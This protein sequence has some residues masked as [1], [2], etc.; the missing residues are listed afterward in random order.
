MLRNFVYWHHIERCYP[1]YTASSGFQVAV[2]R[3]TVI[4]VSQSAWIVVVA[5]RTSELWTMTAFQCYVL[6]KWWHLAGYCGCEM[7]NQDI[8]SQPALTIQFHVASVIR[9]EVILL[10]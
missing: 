6:W 7:S 8:I 9:Y 1:A 4:C 3:L 2:V 10:N 5:V